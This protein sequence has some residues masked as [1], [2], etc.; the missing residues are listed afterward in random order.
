M[1][2]TIISFNVPY[3]PI[4]VKPYDIECIF[5]KEFGDINI[6][7]DIIVKL[8]INTNCEFLVLF[9]IL[10]TT[11]PSEE[12]LE[13]KQRIK[14][15]EVLFYYDDI[16]NYFEATTIIPKKRKC[17]ISNED[18][19]EVKLSFNNTFTLENAAEE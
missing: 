2:L 4:H 19:E 16:G 13:F 11:D 1:A 8:D 7:L 9:V 10:S 14:H 18:I 6:K 12:L 15:E 5:K 3:V 17:F